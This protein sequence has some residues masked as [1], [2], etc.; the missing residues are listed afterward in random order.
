MS[1]IE[2]LRKLGEIVNYNEDEI[3]FQ[4]GEKGDYAFLILRGKVAVILNSIYDGSEIPIAEIGEGD[5]VGEMAVLDV[6][7]RAATVKS[8]SPVIALKIKE[9]HF[10]EFIKMNPKYAKGLLC[11]LS[12][13]IKMT[14]E[15]IKER[16]DS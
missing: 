10:T 5:I 16:V 1:N 11:S 4:Q 12:R 8:I 2:E 9:T 6:S 3:L 14:R 15:K 13:R 7:T